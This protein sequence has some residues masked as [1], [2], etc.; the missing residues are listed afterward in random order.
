KGWKDNVAD[1]TL[2]ATLAAKTYGKGLGLT[3]DEQTL[4]SK[5]ENALISTADT[6]ANGLFTITDELVQE[7]IATLA[8]AGVNITADK[9]FDLSFINNIYKADP[10][11]I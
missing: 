9:L 6:Q 5:G 4:E 3:V 8:I 2:G 10:T 1:P 11:L 7:N